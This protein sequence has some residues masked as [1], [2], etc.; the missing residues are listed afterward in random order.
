MTVPT[1]Y[2]GRDGVVRL[3]VWIA[4]D[5]GDLRQHHIEV[6]LMCLCNLA[7][8]ATKEFGRQVVGNGGPM[9]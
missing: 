7:D 9:G 5:R 1:L 2:S 3:S 8:D 4:D 6:D